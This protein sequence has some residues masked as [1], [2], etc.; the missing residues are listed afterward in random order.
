ML[1]PLGGAVLLLVIVVVHFG[2]LGRHD[3]VIDS[4]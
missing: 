2:V 3:I 4:A 1:R